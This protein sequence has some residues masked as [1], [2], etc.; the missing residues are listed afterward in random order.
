MEQRGD[1]KVVR[2]VSET[3]PLSSPGFK[4]FEELEPDQEVIVVH[5]QILTENEILKERS[6]GLESLA[7]NM[8]DLQEMMLCL[9][10]HVLQDGEKV[11]AIDVHVENAAFDMSVGEKM[12][13]QA[14]HLKGAAL[15][16]VGATIGFIAGG[17]IGAVAGVRI[18]LAVSLVGS[19]A[20]YVGGRLIR[21]AKGFCFQDLGPGMPTSE[22]PIE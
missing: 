2:Q 16:A 20:G 3:S 14:R 4:D 5:E 11:H 17:P 15:P 7:N 1:D 18:G 13:R 12:L 9:N 19:A 21:S 22:S 10:Q 6:S 8:A